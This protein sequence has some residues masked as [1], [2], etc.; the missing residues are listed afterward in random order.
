M[1]EKVEVLEHHADLA[2][3]FV[4]PLEVTGE[5]DPFDDDPATLMLL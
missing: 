5:F 1:R 4:D 3:D 2:A